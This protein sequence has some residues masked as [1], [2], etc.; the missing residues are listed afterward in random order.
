MYRTHMYNIDYYRLFSIFLHLFLLN[1]RDKI[2]KKK[3]KK[4]AYNIN[5]VHALKRETQIKC[6]SM[7]TTKA[8]ANKENHLKCK[9]NNKT[10]I[11]YAYAYIIYLL[12]YLFL[13]HFHFRF[14][15]FFFLF[16][17]FFFTYK[18]SA[19]FAFSLHHMTRSNIFD[20][21]LG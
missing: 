7:A 16:L 15:F 3:K 13:H 2:K 11:I 17:F 6:H 10:K 5:E 9:Q 1:K 14:F 18:V 4:R 20:D 19:L 12:K 21:L 8:T